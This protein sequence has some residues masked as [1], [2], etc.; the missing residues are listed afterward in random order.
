MVF[1]GDI[2]ESL[3]RETVVAPLLGVGQVHGSF[4][5]VECSGVVPLQDMEV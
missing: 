2:L 5:L 1:I 4:A 3:A